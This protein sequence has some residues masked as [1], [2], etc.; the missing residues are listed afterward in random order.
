MASVI[1]LRGKWRA[2]VRRG[3]ARTTKTFSTE[4]EARAWAASLEA[5]Y[6]AT[7]PRV[8]GW[9]DLSHSALHRTP[10][11]ATCG[12]YFLF[13]RGACVYVGRSVKVYSRIEDHFR[14]KEFDEWA[15]IS[16]PMAEL[17]EAELHFIKTLRP[18]LNIVHNCPRRGNHLSINPL[19]AA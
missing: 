10:I 5:L 7:R 14:A 19:E 8:A 11:G 9:R 13:L 15:W 12:I 16:V 4:A 17:A 2:Q 18:A 1:Q 3:E 6:D